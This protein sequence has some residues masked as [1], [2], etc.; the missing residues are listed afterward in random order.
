M[1]K[2]LFFLISSALFALALPALTSPTYAITGA[3]NKFGIHVATPSEQDIKDGAALVNT[4][5]SWGYITVVLQE[6]DRDKKSLQH[7]CDH[8]RDNKLIPIFR[9][10][11]HGEGNSWALPKKR[12]AFAWADVLGSLNCSVK[13]IYVTLF[14]EVNMATEWGGAVNPHQYADIANF[15]ATAIKN[16]NPDVQVLLAGLNQTA[17]HNPPYFY[18]ARLFLDEILNDRSPL[19][20]SIDG[21]ASHSYPPD[22]IGSPSARGLGSITGYQIEQE[23]FEKNCGRKLPVFITETGW[24]NNALPISTLKDYY[25]TAFEQVW[26]KDDSVK[27]VTLYDLN[28]SPPNTDF[29]YR[30]ATAEIHGI[31]EQSSTCG[32]F[33][34]IYCFIKNDLQKTNGDPAQK[35]SASILVTIP[36][37]VIAN[38]TYEYQIWIKNNPTKS[39]ATWTKED[40]YRI[41]FTDPRFPGSFT[42]FHNVKPGNS[43]ITT[44]TFNSGTELKTHPLKVC[45]FKGSECVNEL[46]EWNLT[47]VAP[48]KL[49]IEAHVFPLTNAVGDGYELQIFRARDEKLVYKNP[50]VSFVDGKATI[51][52]VSGIALDEAYRI[53]LLGKSKAYLPVQVASY[54]F[55][56]KDDKIQ[57]PVFMP[58]DFNGDGKFTLSDILGR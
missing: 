32:N 24:K 28:G 13:N 42:D 10:A 51:G 23:I 6:K 26:L 1:K 17:P 27:A 9:L 37:T 25:K 16:K 3:N 47:V 21:I 57:F 44:L 14:N 29:A 2:G 53:V 49:A 38:S 58:L 45:L 33:R 54:L 56:G 7:M 46:F 12:D 39:T 34:E 4:N 48:P 15:F 43:F 22:F 40:G 18:S 20:S 35:Y 8:F 19:C 5:G 31:V 52:A 50:N 30:A 41:G 11:S 55:T 36:Q